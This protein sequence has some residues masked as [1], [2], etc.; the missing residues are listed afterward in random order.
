MVK[1]TIAHALPA[2][3]GGTR[4]HAERCPKSKVISLRG[5]FRRTRSPGLIGECNRTIRQDLFQGPS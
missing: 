4:Q 2:S 1:P 5:R 3:I